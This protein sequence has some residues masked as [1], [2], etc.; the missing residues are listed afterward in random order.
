MM[1]FLK[2]IL[3]VNQY[4]TLFQ[5]STTLFQDQHM[6]PGL[7]LWTIGLI[8]FQFSETLGSY[9]SLL[10]LSRVTRIFTVSLLMLPEKLELIQFGQPDVHR[11]ENEEYFLGQTLVMSGCLPTEPPCL[12]EVIGLE[13]DSVGCKIQRLLRQAAHFSRIPLPKSPDNP[14]YLC[15]EDK[16]Q[17]QQR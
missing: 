9:F 6:D 16:F 1:H 3:I 8:T 15:Q 11:L 4:M 2:S 5:Y 10:G 13:N 17:I 12:L 7:I 14:M